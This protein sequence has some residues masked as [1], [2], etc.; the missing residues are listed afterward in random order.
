ML[1][2]RWPSGAPL[3]RAP[4]ADDPALAGDEW[5][6]NHFIYDDDTRPSQPVHVTESFA[7]CSANRK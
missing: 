6:N 4:A 7:E 2:G 3:M 1:V 5:A